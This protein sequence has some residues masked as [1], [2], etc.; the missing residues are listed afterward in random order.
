MTAVLDE[1]VAKHQD[2]LCADGQTAEVSSTHAMGSIGQ[3]A[4]V[5]Q[6]KCI[7]G[8]N[9]RHLVCLILLQRLGE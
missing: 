6:S 9:T 4:T 2:I 1:A 7:L 3:S 8:I 5:L